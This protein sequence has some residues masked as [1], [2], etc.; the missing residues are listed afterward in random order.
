MDGS[1]SK[2]RRDDRRKRFRFQMDAELRYQFTEGVRGQPINGTGQVLDISSKAVAFRAD[3][4]IACG[5]RLNVSMAWPVKL[6]ECSLRLALEGTV[7]RVRGNLVVVSIERT[8]FRTAGRS[9]ASG[10]GETADNMCHP[11]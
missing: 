10:R 8:E 7:L 3:T 6:D 2:F 9:M 1:L 4:P 11:D 5:S